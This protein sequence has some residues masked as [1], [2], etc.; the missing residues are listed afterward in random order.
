MLSISFWHINLWMNCDNIFQKF[1]YWKVFK[2]QKHFCQRF[3]SWKRSVNEYCGAFRAFLKVTEPSYRASLG[4]SFFLLVQ[5]PVNSGGILFISI[6]WLQDSLLYG[7]MFYTKST[8]FSSQAYLLGLMVFIN[9]S[10]TVEHHKSK[11]ISR[12]NKSFNKRAAAFE[13]TTR[14]IPAHY[15]Q[16]YPQLEP[17][18]DG[19]I[20][21]RTHRTH[22]ASY[23][24]AYGI[25]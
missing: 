2:T 18:A 8:P 19:R 21:R 10:D 6:T 17:Y 13:A 24:F 1:A 22:Y 23:I 15:V 7:E 9:R 14:S 12:V 25:H 5:R 20:R 16:S 3:T 11:C 4:I